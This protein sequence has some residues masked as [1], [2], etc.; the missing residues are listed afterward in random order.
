MA[1][2]T[3]DMRLS[4]GHPA[5][6]F[7]N[8][9]DSRRGRWGPDF[10]R[11]FADLLVLADRLDLVDQQAVACLRK[12][13]EDNP[14]K[15]AAALA[16]A[17]ALRES[18]Y[19]LFLSEDAAEPHPVAD[20]RLVEDW[21]RRGRAQQVL[22]ANEAGYAWSS[23]FDDLSQLVQLFAIKA[24]DLLMERDRRRAVRECKGSNCG[25][26]FIDHSKSGRRVWCSDASCGSH[27]RIR[28]FRSRAKG[29]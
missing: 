4:G 10:L 26:L 3:A 8:T 19:R 12:Q 5:L 23:P 27:A 18:M 16:D 28:R 15:A 9:V 6:D 29:T 21:A 2:S 20:L 14:S 17:L 24:V 11:S 25:W 13:A 7:T 1:T 22:V